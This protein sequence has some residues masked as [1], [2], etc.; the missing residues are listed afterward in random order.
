MIEHLNL[1]A[2]SNESTV[3]DLV[4]TNANNPVTGETLPD[5]SACFESFVDIEKSKFRFAI[6]KKK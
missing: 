6:L 1:F 4:T 3:N 2:E 5:I